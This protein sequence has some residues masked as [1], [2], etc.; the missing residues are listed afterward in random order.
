MKT[1]GSSDYT[2]QLLKMVLR[3]HFT[4]KESD[5]SLFIPFLNSYSQEDWP[6]GELDLRD[7]W[8]SILKVITTGGV[9]PRW[10]QTGQTSHAAGQTDSIQ[11]QPQPL[12][13]EGCQG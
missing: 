10:E 2:H 13:N 1:A 3:G 8:W 5:N 4:Y 12:K 11:R 7:W 9:V 6:D